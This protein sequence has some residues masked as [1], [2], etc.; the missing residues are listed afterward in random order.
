ML[1]QEKELESL[2]RELQTMAHERV[3]I[4]V[5]SRQIRN[6]TKRAV[7]SDSGVTN[8]SRGC[9]YM[10]SRHTGTS[11]SRLNSSHSQ[12]NNPSGR[13]HLSLSAKSKQ[14]A[15]KGDKDSN[16]DAINS[17]IAIPEYKPFERQKRA[18]S[19][20]QGDSRTVANRLT[21]RSANDTLVV[22]SMR[23]GSLVSNYFLNQSSINL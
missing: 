8:G 7:K 3:V 5:F 9:G 4:D 12:P 11:S 23:Q 15:D 21:V 18:P 2:K 10:R 20:V 19:T 1:Q 22:P 14:T 6:D 13:Q 17:A 16:K